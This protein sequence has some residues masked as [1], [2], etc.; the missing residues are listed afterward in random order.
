MFPF[1][2]HSQLPDLLFGSC[3]FSGSNDLGKTL[4]PRGESLFMCI[5]ESRAAPNDVAPKFSEIFHAHG[6]GRGWGGSELNS[7]LFMLFLQF[8]CFF[9]AIFMLFMLF[10][11]FSIDFCTEAYKA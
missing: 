2:L 8:L 4:A 9:Y 3:S 1:F 10:L 6:L 11:R 5:C 7:M